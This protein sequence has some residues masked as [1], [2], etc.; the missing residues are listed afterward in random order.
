MN[1]PQRY[2]ITAALP[3]A[4]GPSHIGHMAGAYLPADI[5][6]R[7]LRRRKRDVVFICGSDE[8]GAAITI[9]AKKENK[10]PKEIV[11][12]YHA[13]IKKTFEDF[14][15]SFDIYHRTSEPIHHETSQE[16]FLKLYENNIFEEKENEQYYDEQF[17]QFLA[18]RY[19]TGTCPVCA[20]PNAYGDQCERCGTSLSPTDLINPI[21]TL[22]NKAPIKRKTKHWYL[23]LNKFEEWLKDWII[24]GN[25]RSEEWKKNVMGQCASWLNEGLHPRAITRDLDWGVKVPLPDAEGKVLYVWMD[26]PI[27]YISAT[28][29]WAID[30][31]RDWKPYWQHADTKLLHFI[32]KDNIVFHC[33]IFPCIL[34]SHGDYI[35][36]T[37][38][39]ANEFMNLEGEKISTSRNWNI[40]LHEYLNEFPGKEDVMRYVLA[41]NFP[42]TKDS[43]FTWKD[44]QA[45]NNNEL[46]AILGN[47]MNRVLVLTHK[48]CDGKIPAENES[49]L[50]E[51]YI[52]EYKKNI[53]RIINE[54]YIPA[55][56]NY[57]FRDGMAAMM[58]VVRLGNKLLT[59]YEPWKLIKTDVEKTTGVLRICLESMIDIA[60]LCEPY[61]PF[62]AKKI[63]NVLNVK[64]TNY[65]FE[66]CQQ[67]LSTEN[68]IGEAV[69]L[70]EKIDDAVIH[71][72][73]EELEIIHNRRI[74]QQNINTPVE[75][76]IYTS[77]KSTIQFDEFAK[78]DLRTGIII[79]AEK[80]PKTDKL[81]KLKVDIGFEQRTIL[82][83][84]AQHFTPSELINKKVTVVV[85]L[86][87]RIMKGIESNGMILMAEDAKGKLYFIQA[88][89]LKDGGMTVS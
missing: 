77:V 16:F 65:D 22:S 39:P 88:E 79:E 24:D 32:G 55:I 50:N 82:S 7:Y 37:N 84:I 60:I 69:Y 8:H 6:V 47:F 56:E 72:K 45:K 26:A 46:V 67:R 21:S 19:I 43:E 87:P 28:K 11:D 44:F 4:N 14:A 9:Q 36:P 51:N 62:T 23:P 10:T 59:D 63:F 41:S 5:Y 25:G 73:L 80:I 34:K 52:I 53:R 54:E 3:Y 81:L 85:N 86:A 71:K 48:Y 64:N 40:Q 18:D 1:N 83:G 42:E 75:T 31:N 57:R 58:D 27:G 74:E 20:N 35:L 30:N 2:L 76:K 49:L 13:I 61:L 38:V 89:G 15:I 68:K 29:Q 78:L 17:N 66:F 70:F 33:L 12:K